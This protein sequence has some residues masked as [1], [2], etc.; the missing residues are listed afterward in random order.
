MSAIVDRWDGADVDD[1]DYEAAQIDQDAPSGS[2]AALRI[3][4]GAHLEANYQRLVAQLYAITLD[5]GEAHDV[6]Q[7]AYSRAWRNW[8]TISRKPDPTAWVRSVAVRATMRSWRRVLAKLGLGR[9]HRIAEG[10]DPRTR[11]LLQAL[12]RLTPAERRAVV[13]YHMAGASV[14]EIAAV[15]QVNPEIVEARLGAA[16]NVVVEGLADE[17]PAVLSGAQDAQ[18]NEGG[19]G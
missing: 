18:R 2:L 17:L 1:D 7:D 12:A 9:K 5:P 4:F 16:R 10:V 6:V 14:E 3:D 8:A 15:E 13:L 19:D 11:A